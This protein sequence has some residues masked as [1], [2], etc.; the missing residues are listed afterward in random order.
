MSEKPEDGKPELAA[1]IRD[2]IAKV[3]KGK[4]VTLDD[5]EVVEIVGVVGLRLGK[6]PDNLAPPTIV[7]W[8]P[9][10]KVRALKQAMLKAYPP[11]A[12]ASVPTSGDAAAMVATKAKAAMTASDMKKIEQSLGK[13][14]PGGANIPDARL[15]ADPP[16]KE[17]VKRW[18]DDDGIFWA[19]ESQVAQLRANG[20]CHGK[21]E[22]VLLDELTERERLLIATLNPALLGKELVETI[23][24]ATGIK[25]MRKKP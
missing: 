4:S 25:P 21:I 13:P 15:A 5:L 7:Y 18:R 8:W 24:R 2:A 12:K 3:A 6:S 19:T 16:P 1:M 9:V 11:E 22:E 17:E 10:E 14:L 20:E 23:Q